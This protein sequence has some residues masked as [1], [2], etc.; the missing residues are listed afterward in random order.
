M[1]AP[2]FKYPYINT[3]KAR[4]LARLL[5]GESLTHRSFDSETHT[6]RLSSSIHELRVDGW[7]IVT[8]SRIAA[9]ADPTGRIAKYAIYCLQREVIKMTGAEGADFMR[10]VFEWEALCSE[11]E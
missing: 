4:C 2:V 8:L 1:E 10:Q 5:C 11:S 7:P 9:T 6:Y 3:L